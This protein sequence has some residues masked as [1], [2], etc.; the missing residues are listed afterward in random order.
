M[1]FRFIATIGICAFGLA[2]CTGQAFF[3][4]DYDSHKKGLVKICYAPN[5][6]SEE[7]LRTMADEACELTNKVARLRSTLSGRCS[8]TAPDLAIFTCEKPVKRN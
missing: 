7:E 2:G 1:T 4:T 6:T 8:W 5:Q 3:E